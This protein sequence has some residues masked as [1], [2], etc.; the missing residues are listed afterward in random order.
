MGVTDGQALESIGLE[1]A[2]ENRW[3]G[4]QQ[5][6]NGRIADI[7]NQMTGLQETGTRQITNIEARMEEFMGRLERHHDDTQWQG[8]HAWREG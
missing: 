3:T 1:Q 6:M 8:W 5:A 4:L 7:E 2:I